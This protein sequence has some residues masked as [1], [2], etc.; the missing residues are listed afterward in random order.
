MEKYNFNIMISIDGNK[1]RH[2]KYR[3]FKNGVGSYDAVIKAISLIQNKALLNAR[4]TITDVNLSIYDYIGTILDLGIKRITFTVDYN[5]TDDNFILYIDAIKK[6]SNKYLTDIKN[7]SFY[8]LTNFTKIL[9]LVIFH[10]KCKA[11]CNA[12]ISYITMS[13]D[14]KYYLCPRFFG[15]SKFC[16]GDTNKTLMQYRQSLNTKQKNSAADRSFNCK[17]CCFVFICG[18]VCMHHAYV[19][20]KNIFGN[21]L[22]ECEERKTIIKS[23]LNLLCSLSISERRE[24]LLFLTKIWHDNN[25]KEVNNNGYN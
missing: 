21:V 12:G 25:V 16:M 19:S 6:L 7:G 22:R 17:K 18:G 10:N 2:N 4:I 8:E 11:H 15:I 20:T 3:C 13:A 1:E 23:A 9:S 24:F 5:I 14:G